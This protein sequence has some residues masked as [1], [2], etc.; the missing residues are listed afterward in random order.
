M[1]NLGFNVKT[2]VLTKKMALETNRTYVDCTN[3]KTSTIF[4]I[5]KGNETK[6]ERDQKNKNCYYLKFK[7]CESLQVIERFE[8]A[9]LAGLMDKE[10]PPAVGE[11]G[12]YSSIST[13]NLANNHSNLTK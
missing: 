6:I 12:E 5:A 4:V 8:M 2:A 11:V 7:D 1:A 13:N 9:T 3:N 10:L